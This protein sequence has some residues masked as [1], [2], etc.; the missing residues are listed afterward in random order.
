M[1][2]EARL[3]AACPFII[4]SGLRCKA[5]NKASGGSASSSHLNGTA[6]DIATRNSQERHD[7]L[8]GLWAAGFARIGI[9]NSFIHVDVDQTK[10]VGVVWTY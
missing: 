2:D 5:H 9:A 7:V 8:S 3:L 10:P 4:T 1:L 6:V